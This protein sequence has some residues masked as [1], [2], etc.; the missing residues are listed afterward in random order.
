ME[1]MQDWMTTAES[2][3]SRVSDGDE[4]LAAW[5]SLLNDFYQH[6]PLLLKLS[7]KAITVKSFS[8]L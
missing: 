7:H 1:K 6:L 5:H 3:R 2:F 4:V 8:T